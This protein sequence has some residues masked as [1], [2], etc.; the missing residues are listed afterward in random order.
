MAFELTGMKDVEVSLDAGT[1]WTSIAPILP[2]SSHSPAPASEE[3][4]SGE[5]GYAGDEDAFELHSTALSQYS[6]L[7]A[8][9]RS[10]GTAQ[11]RLTDL[12]GNVQVMQDDAATPLEYSLEVSKPYGFATKKKNHMIVKLSVF[13]V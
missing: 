8:Q 4:S 11:L 13:H 3:F 10:D 9:Q 2:D 12:A 1:T 7:R 5:K 6:S